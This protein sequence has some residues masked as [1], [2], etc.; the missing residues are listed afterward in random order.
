MLL[1]NRNPRSLLV[2]VSFP[3]SAQLCKTWNNS[4]Y[5]WLCQR[6]HLLH[7]CHRQKSLAQC[8]RLRVCCRQET[9]A[10]C[11][12]L[13]PACH[14]QKWLAQCKRL[15]PVC[16]RQKLQAQCKHLLPVCRRQK[17]QAQCKCLLP[18]CY[19]QK[20]LAIFT[21][22]YF[23]FYFASSEEKLI[24]VMISNNWWLFWVVAKYLS[25]KM[26]SLYC[27]FE[28][29]EVKEDAYILKNCFS[30][31]VAGEYYSKKRI[32]LLTTWSEK[33]QCT[34]V[35]NV[36]RNVIIDVSWC[37]HHCFFKLGFLSMTYF[38]NFGLS[39]LYQRSIYLF[40]F[41][42]DFLFV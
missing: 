31:R 14:R 17:S 18:V 29:N 9:L 40:L 36:V 10:H 11:K 12:R 16:L 38:H 28:V 19:R 27:Y 7:V 32:W 34:Q 13:L 41:V 39:H 22:W 15:L 35:Y 1:A 26:Y 25:Y 20:S 21:F 30:F 33:W 37:H 42:W 5:W 3:F 24:L 23:G 4:F 2:Q 6:K 8:K